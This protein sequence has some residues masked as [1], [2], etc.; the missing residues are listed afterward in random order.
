MVSKRLEILFNFLAIL[1][2]RLIGQ[3]LQQQAF[4]P[5]PQIQPL[6]QARPRYSPIFFTTDNQEHLLKSEHYEHL[7]MVTYTYVN[8]VNALFLCEL[9]SMHCFAQTVMTIHTQLER[10]Q[11]RKWNQDQEKWLIVYYAEVFTLGVVQGLGP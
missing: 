1:D 10:D 5:R 3:P 6:F 2:V 7:F 4:V 11:Y 8:E 9:K